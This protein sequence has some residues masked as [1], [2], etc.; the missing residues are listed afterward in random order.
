MAGGNF[1][2]SLRVNR[3]GIV[4]AAGPFDI[5]V[6]EV[7]EMCVWVLQRDGTDDAIANNMGMP[8]MPG[9]PSKLKVFD[10]GTPEAH[11]TFPLDDR[12]KKVD[13]RAGSATAMATGVFRDKNGKQR[14]FFWSEPV[15]LIGPGAKKP[16]R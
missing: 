13:F 8:D 11:W 12:F 16:P 5:S 14:G 10:L 15:R 7:T 6:A 3:D 9:M 4:Q 1:N 2:G